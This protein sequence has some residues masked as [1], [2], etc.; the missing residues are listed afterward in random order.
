MLRMLIGGNG[1]L[2]NSIVSKTITKCLRKNFGCKSAK[3]TAED[4]VVYRLEGDKL[5][6]HLNGDLE[7]DKEELLNLINNKIGESE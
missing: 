6:I 4:F 7:I 2:L 5:L 3:A 1:K